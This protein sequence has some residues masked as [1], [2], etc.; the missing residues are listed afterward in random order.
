MGPPKISEYK[1]SIKFEFLRA[2]MTQK[3]FINLANYKYSQLSKNPNFK[4]PTIIKLQYFDA[5]ARWC[6]HVY[7]V[8]KAQAIIDQS[9][10]IEEE[11]KASS[12]D[13]VLQHEIEKLIATAA[14][15]PGV[16]HPSLKSSFSSDLRKVRNKCSFHCTNSRVKTDILSDFMKTHHQEIYFVFHLLTTKPELLGVEHLNDLGAIETFYDIDFT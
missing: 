2:Q 7:E 13:D 3:E 11:S 1:K 10:S 9:I 16:I 4:A 15:Q 6:G 5:Y 8:I 14:Q 12:F